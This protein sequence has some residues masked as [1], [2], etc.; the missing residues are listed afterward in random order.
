MIQ[1]NDSYNKN[2]D[3]DV[4]CA[5]KHRF[6]EKFEVPEVALPVIDEIVTPLEQRVVAALADMT[7]D[8][9]EI[10]RVLFCPFSLAELSLM[11][12]EG[13]APFDE[14]EVRRFTE[15]AYRRGIISVDETDSSAGR[16]IDGAVPHGGRDTI[17]DDE[18]IPGEGY[19]TISTGKAVPGKGRNMASV[20]ETVAGGGGGRRYRIANFYGRLDI[21]AVAEQD[22]WQ[23]LPADIRAALDQWCFDIYYAGLDWNRNGGAPT[24]DRILTLEETLRYIDENHEKGRQIYLTDCDCRSLRGDCD[25]PT[26]V[27]LSYRNGPNSYPDRGISKPVTHR[28]AQAAVIAADRA[29]LVHTVNPNGICN[30]CEDCCY[31]FRARR[32]RDSGA[33]WPESRRA[34]AFEAGRCLGCGICL[35]RCR[36]G[37]FD[38]SDFAAERRASVDVSRCV[39]CGVCVGTCPSDALRLMPR[40][41]E[42]T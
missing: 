11:S 28:E 8:A 18:T 21:F 25:S 12:L 23:A 20:D 1:S 13:V 38:R 9:A 31:L 27:C 40:E 2:K 26:L 33:V 22:A 15:D 4:P 17:S 5:D 7:F 41:R 34:V 14:A 30:C 24:D 6:L 32:R 36:F 3:G 16:N 29:A 35:G 19:S 37:V 42:A 39:G 10:G